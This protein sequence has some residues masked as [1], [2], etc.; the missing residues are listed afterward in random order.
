MLE[1]LIIVGFCVIVAIL[2]TAAGFL[3]SKYLTNENNWID[4]MHLQ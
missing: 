3:I 4:C 2:M 1:A